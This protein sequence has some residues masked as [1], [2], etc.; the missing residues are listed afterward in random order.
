MNHTFQRLLEGMANTLRKEIIPNLEGEYAR[1]QA[2]GVIY[3][4]NSIGLRGDWSSDFFRPQLQMLDDLNETLT[5]LLHGLNAPVLHTP[6][7]VQGH[8]ASQLQARLEH[9]N[10]YVC[11]LLDWL[12]EQGAALPAQTSTAI[13]TA[14]KHYM[15]QQV[16][17]EIKTTAKPMFAQ[18]S[19]GDE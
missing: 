10:T 16:A 15:G 5:P 7:P 17:W 4:L 13:E 1:G 8:E 11:A 19:K 14:I 12:H 2:Y 18:I 3:M 9:G 6:A